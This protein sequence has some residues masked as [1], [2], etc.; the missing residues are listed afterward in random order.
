[1]GLTA[2]A[3]EAMTNSEPWIG[4]NVSAFELHGLVS[5]DRPKLYPQYFGGH[6]EKSAVHYHVFLCARPSPLRA[7]S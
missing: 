1:M 3:G 6:I 2:L 4:P 7:I 5:A